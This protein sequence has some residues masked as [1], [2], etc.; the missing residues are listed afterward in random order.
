MFEFSRRL[1]GFTQFLQED[2][3]LEPWNIDLFQI[4]AVAET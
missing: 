4:Y 1:R 2:A 3:E